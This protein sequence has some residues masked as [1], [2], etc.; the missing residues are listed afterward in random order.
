[1][2]G[3]RGV[4]F[5]AGNTLLFVDRDRL[6]LAFHEAGVEPDGER[7]EAIEYRARQRLAR[8]AAEGS[9]T[10]AHVWAEYFESIFRECGVL[11]DRLAAVGERVRAMHREL[12][13][14]T[15][16]LPGTPEALDALRARGL[17]LGVISNADGRVAL[18][19]ERAGLLGFFETVVD[20]GLVGVE[21]PDPAIFQ[22]ALQRLGIAPNQALY[23]GD[24]YPVDVLG[25]RGAGMHALLV[26]PL[27]E[28]EATCERVRTVTELPSYL[29]ANGLNPDGSV[30]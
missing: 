16:V 2:N 19:L 17:R 24:L 12:D 7:F 29:G 28:V 6:F 21:K 22:I 25:A 14:W 3:L 4:Y 23:V 27:G 26:D 20:S 1:M 18:L 8:R 11:E 9:G 30:P 5:D 15:R 13:L 10:E